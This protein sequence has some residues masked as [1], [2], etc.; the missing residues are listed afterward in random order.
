MKVKTTHGNGIG[1][2]KKGVRVQKGGRLLGRGEDQCLRSEEGH[3]KCEGC[4]EPRNVGLL[5]EVRVQKG[6]GCWECERSPERGNTGKG[7]NCVHLV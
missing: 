3:L 4:S 2:Q 1:N 5:R 7:R 6:E